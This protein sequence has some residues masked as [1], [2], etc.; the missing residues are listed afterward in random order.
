MST[1]A[2]RLSVLGARFGPAV[3]LMAVIFTFSA[4]PGSD[5]P[6]FGVWNLLVKKGGHALGYALLGAAYA[7]A[8]SPLARPSR[9]Q[10]ALAVGLAALYALSD[11][12][13]QSLTPGR[14]PALSDVLIDTLGAWLGV[15]VYRRWRR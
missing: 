11:E 8:F 3:A 1:L 14:H 15:S 13:H 7:H 12:W 10:T 5:L 2:G 6:H 9:R 4:T